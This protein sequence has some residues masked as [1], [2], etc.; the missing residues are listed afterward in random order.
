M[1][2]VVQRVTHGSVTVNDNKTGQISSGALVLVCAEPHDQLG[3]HPLAKKLVQ[4]RIF[5]DDQQRMNLSLLQLQDHGLLL[6]PQF[7]LAADCS[8]GNRPSFQ[9]AAK[10][11]WGL[12][13]FNDFKKECEML[14][15][16]P[17]EQG[18]FGADMQVELCNDGPATFILR[19]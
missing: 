4:L 16:R 3:Q 19:S 13:I 2:L 9:N 10:P 12:Q 6:V 5:S 18:E 14:L 1:I 15:E 7:T 11:D 8:K 17:V